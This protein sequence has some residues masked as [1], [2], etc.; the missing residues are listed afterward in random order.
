MLTDA[1]TFGKLPSLDAIHLATA[2]SIGTDRLYTH[3]NECLKP[4]NTSD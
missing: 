1:G 3:D 2:K 4:P